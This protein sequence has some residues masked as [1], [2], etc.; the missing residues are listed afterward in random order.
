ME[1]KKA[2]PKKPPNPP[3]SAY[4]RNYRPPSYD[5]RL[6][7]YGGGGSGP[8]IY[9]PPRSVSLGGRLWGGYDDIGGGYGSFGGS[10]GSG[11]GGGEFGSFGRG[12]LGSY[13]GESSLGYTSHLGS[14]NGDYGGGYGNLGGYSRNESNYDPTPGPSFRGGGYS[15]GSR[16]GVNYDPLPGPSYGSGGPYGGRG[17]GSVGG[18]GGGVGGGR[19]HPY[20]R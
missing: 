9:A 8:G 7:G 20:G 14:Y 15:S 5:D 11:G 19:Y 3:S 12:E 13:R 2:E 18:Y 4:A 10:L 6:S 16:Y 1:I 17:G